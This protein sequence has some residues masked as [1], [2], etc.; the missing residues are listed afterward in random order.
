MPDP[1]GPVLA[2]SVTR[3][4]PDAAGR[5]VVSGSHGGTY[6]TWLACRS[7]CRA[8]ILHDAGVGLDEAGIGGLAWL[9]RLGLAA[10]AVDHASAPIGQAERMLDRGRIS[11]ANAQA[12]ACGLRPGMPCR[13]AARRLAAAPERHGPCPEVAEARDVLHLPAARRPL[14]LIDSASLVRPEDEGAVIVTG[15]HG[16]LFGTDPRNA[17]KVD[18]R[19]AL[20]NDA[21]GGPGTGRLA[22]LEQR[23]IAA[24]T[25][26][27]NSA[28]IGDARSSWQDGVVSA[29]NRPARDLGARPGLPASDL[30]A[31]FLDM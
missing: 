24:A 4:G 30:V 20:F 14:V 1:D 23:G 7:G 22:P 11:H 27:A 9:E 15:S 31:R 18:A 3:L 19:L 6:A 10:A 13:E 29:A 25:V 26:A 8:V 28:R 12:A 5:V 21:G 2:D 16:A 17:L